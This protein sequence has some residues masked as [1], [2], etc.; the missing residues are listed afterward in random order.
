MVKFKSDFIKHPA[1]WAGILIIV[2]LAV[3]IV[4][5]LMFNAARDAAFLKWV[6]NISADSITQAKAFRFR[7]NDESDQIIVDFSGNDEKSRLASIFNRIQDV[8]IYEAP[9]A[10]DGCSYVLDIAEGNDDAKD[11]LLNVVSGGKMYFTF[12]KASNKEFCTIGKTWWVDSAELSSYITSMVV[13]RESQVNVITAMSKVK[14]TD[15][16]NSS[17]LGNVSAKK[18]ATALR[19]A[20]KEDKLL[21]LSDAEAMGETDIKW[22]WELIP[23]I[24]GDPETG[25]VGSDMH[26]RIRCGLTE[27][28]VEISFGQAGAYDTVK[29]ED[30]NLYQLVRCSKDSK[31]VVKKSPY[32]KYKK[33]LIPQMEKA[34]EST[35]ADLGT[36]SGYKVTRFVKVWDYKDN[37]GST[38]K[39]YDFKFALLPEEPEKLVMTGGMYLDSKARLHGL[40]AGQFAVRE[41]KGKIVSC[42]FMGNDFYYSPESGSKVFTKD[43]EERKAAKS[44]INGAL[45]LA[46]KAA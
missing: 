26:F 17:D 27:N 45:A 46:E 20:A 33:Y 32:K 7:E 36:F 43:I 10:A 16:V 19:R 41:K 15:F 28:I 42:A 2:L 6:Q 31:T 3:E 35:T 13:N 12:D 30:E 5:V 34:L 9:P 18:L 8:N 4:S 39:L 23:A 11:V 22:F 38:V 44:R 24:E 40:D 29:L 25:I 21:A 37:D 14:S 1:F